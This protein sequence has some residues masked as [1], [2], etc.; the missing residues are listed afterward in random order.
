MQPKVDRAPLMRLQPESEAA[1]EHLKG[2]QRENEVDR[3]H[4]IRIQRASEA[5]RELLEGLH[6]E[7]REGG[8]R[9]PDVAA[10]GKRSE[11]KPSEVPAPAK[12]EAAPQ[13][14]KKGFFSRLWGSKK[15]PAAPVQETK[16]AAAEGG[17]KTPPVPASEKPGMKDGTTDVPMEGK[18]SENN[19][20]NIFPSGL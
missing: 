7:S 1:K 11:A 3:E 2:I 20:F 10:T 15:A 5:A 17:R 19:M 14:A 4:Q 6:Q 16:P 9:T 13:A 8:Q 12:P 18:K